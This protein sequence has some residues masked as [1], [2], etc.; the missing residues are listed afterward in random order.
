MKSYLISD[1]KDTWVGMRLAGINGVIVHSREEV[2][3]AFKQAL[4]NPETGILI[5]TE[6]AVDKIREEVVKQKS[7]SV[8]PLI[9]EIPD[10]HG[11]HNT[12]DIIMD[13]IRECIGIQV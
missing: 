8:I 2:L 6:L 7:K 13:N 10:R 12:C 11:R 5:M 3:V 4:K 9:I 1:N